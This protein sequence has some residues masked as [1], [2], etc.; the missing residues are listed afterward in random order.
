MCLE[1][2]STHTEGIIVL[3]ILPLASA[4]H[5]LARWEQLQESTSPGVTDNACPTWLCNAW[6]KWRAVK[7]YYVLCCCRE[8]CPLPALLITDCEARSPE[9]PSSTQVNPVVRRLSN[10]T[11]KSAQQWGIIAVIKMIL[12]KKGSIGISLSRNPWMFMGWKIKTYI[13]KGLVRKGEG[14]RR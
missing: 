10:G 4:A 1:G 7:T 12:Q 2:S 5:R 8:K 14:R 9:E 6:W 11:S 13:I 3:H